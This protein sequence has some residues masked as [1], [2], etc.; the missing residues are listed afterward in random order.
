MLHPFC[1]GA[2]G[3][4]D[5]TDSLTVPR[6]AC[7]GD[8]HNSTPPWSSCARVWDLCDGKQRRRRMCATGRAPAASAHVWGVPGSR[9]HGQMTGG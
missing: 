9:M 4:F 8:I 2:F 1:L 5:G 3:L 6:V 7:T